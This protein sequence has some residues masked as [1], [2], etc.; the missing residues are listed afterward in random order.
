M[1][2]RDLMAMTMSAGQRWMEN[3]VAGPSLE[4]DPVR[5]GQLA[6]DLEL[7]DESGSTTHL[8]EFWP[9]GPTLVMLWRHLGCGCGIERLERLKTEISDYADAGLKPVVVAPGEIE[10]VIAYKQRYGLP[11]PVLADPEYQTHKAFGLSH[12]SKEQ[13]LYDAPEE[14]CTI[15]REIG[16]QFAEDR[17]MMDRPLVD[18]PWMQSAEFV[19][20]RG[21]V[22]RVAYLY[23]YCEDYP[24][25]RI[26][27]TAARLAG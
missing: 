25:M 21:G 23:N 5:R 10:R 27:T 18:D 24:D 17:R 6:P 12:W 8:S 3:W 26:F 20:D 9:T 15:T 19:V 16:E 7:T 1:S 13:V 14:Y 2:D 4:G 11:V 22:V